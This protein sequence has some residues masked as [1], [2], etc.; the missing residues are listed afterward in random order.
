VP[1]I[2]EALEQPWDG[3]LDMI[4]DQQDTVRKPTGT[5]WFTPSVAALLLANLVPLY[6]VFA[7]GWEVFPIMLLFWSENVIIGALNVFKMLLAEPGNRAKWVGKILV[8]PFFCF[9][10]GMF[11][12]V[13][14]VFV[15]GFFGG[16]F[17]QGAPFP[18]ENLF[19]QMVV[20]KRLGWALLGLALSHIF[21]FAWNYV[22]RG[23]Y[24]TASLQMLMSQP[25]GRV[26]VMHL[27]VLGGGFLMTALQSPAAGLA[28][29]VALKTGFDLRAHLQEREKFLKTSPTAI[30]L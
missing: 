7:L 16:Q 3:D 27:T 25:Y 19:W 20:E 12:F 4:A 29:L 1:L 21:S 23:E 22:G 28:V 5:A 26:V 17:R 10:Y 14:G 15:A 30:A 24:R 2:R 8:I 18:N 6:G 9:H 13:H 11:T